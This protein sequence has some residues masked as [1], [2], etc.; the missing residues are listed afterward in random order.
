[1]TQMILD[2]GGQGLAMPES[3]KGGYVIEPVNLYQDMEMISGR[4]VREY[5]GEAWQASHQYGYF[6]DTDKDRFLAAC[7]KGTR[8]S[9]LCTVLLQEQNRDYTGT[10]V[11]VSYRPPKFMWS[12][13]GKPV[14]A[15]YFVQIREVR[16]HA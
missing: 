11:V 16:P 7:R 12:A 6:N 4:Y 15:D 5:R 9:I 8:G 2:V 3:I 1:M 14:W 13:D 10:F